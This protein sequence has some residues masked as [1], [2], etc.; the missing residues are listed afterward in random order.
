M[1]LADAALGVEGGVN[2]GLAGYLNVMYE[3]REKLWLHYFMKKPHEYNAHGAS[4]LGADV[5]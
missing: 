4:G 2:V 1:H 3:Q 5:F